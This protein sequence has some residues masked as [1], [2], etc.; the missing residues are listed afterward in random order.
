MFTLHVINHGP[1]LSTAAAADFM[2]IV[3]IDELEPR[4]SSLV[5]RVRG[6]KYVSLSGCS[7]P[8]NTNHQIWR[9]Y[10]TFTSAIS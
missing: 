4:G 10:S 5:P 1:G 7:L 6:D 2:H 8:C 9:P 3:T